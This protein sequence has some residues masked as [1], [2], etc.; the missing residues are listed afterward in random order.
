MKLPAMEEETKS[1]S[2]PWSP[3][4]KLI[5]GLT[6]TSLVAALLIY[7]RSFIGPLLLAIVLAYALHPLAAILSRATRL[8]WRW[9]VNIVFLV[10]V[11]LLLGALTLSGLAII[12]Q[13][14]SLFVIIN[15]FTSNLPALV[16]EISG[17]TFTFGPFVFSLTQYDLQSLV[18]Q[19]L[20]ILQPLIGQ[21]GLLISTFATSALSTLAWGG[22]VL[23][24]AY[25]LLARTGEVTDEMIELDIPGY[26][27]DIKHF[28]AEFRRIWNAFLRGQL[29][30]FLLTIVVYSL[31]LTILGLRYSLGIAILAGVARFIPYIGPLIVWIITVLVALLQP[32]NYFGLQA[33]SYALI[34]LAACLLLDLALDNIVVPR[35]HGRALGLH[36]AAVLVAAIAAA[37]LLGIVGLVLAA[38][39]LASIVLVLRYITRKML[40]L[41]PWPA[42]EITSSTHVEFPWVDLYKRL[43]VWRTKFQRKSSEH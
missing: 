28:T 15:T 2:P 14:Q 11:I 5:V 26:S 18:N 36:P 20:G 4:T 16:E 8:N 42:N 30:I 6:F 29:I 31:L 9:A 34:V 39:V 17:K 21:F 27:D 10:F 23:V 33:W 25:F 22:F 24:I 43:N 13:M 38:P 40:D 7:F 35:F 19:L 1:T 3:T 41:D 37:Q 32:S 12:Q